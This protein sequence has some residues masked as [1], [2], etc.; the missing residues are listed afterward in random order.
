MSLRTQRAYAETKL[1]LALDGNR[2]GIVYEREIDLAHKLCLAGRAY[3]RLQERRCNEDIP[4]EWLEKAETRI[5][6]R[7]KKLL[8]GT[9]LASEVLVFGGDP[10]GCT[11]MIVTDELFTPN[12]RG[13]SQQI[14]GPD[15]RTQRYFK[16]SYCLDN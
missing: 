4:E 5:E 2:N 8:V 14:Y 12:I 11:A 10:R 13:Y 6:N 9:P 7:I 16:T 15:G 3:S 1:A